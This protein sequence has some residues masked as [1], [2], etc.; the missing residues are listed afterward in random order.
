MVPPQKH[1]GIWTC[2]L[3]VLV[4]SGFIL[5]TDEG[6]YGDYDGRDEK[7][8]IFTSSRIRHQH[9]LLR[10]LPDPIYLISIPSRSEPPIW[11]AADEQAMT[12][13]RQRLVCAPLLHKRF[14][15]VVLI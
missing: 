8:Q 13:K 14:V 12:L 15:D 4:N 9:Q 5:A 11:S 6:V 2:A 3:H 1:G 7:R 10:N